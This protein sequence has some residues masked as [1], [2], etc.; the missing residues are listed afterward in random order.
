M[1]IRASFYA[2]NKCSQLHKHNIVNFCVLTLGKRK[3]QRRGTRFDT[4][5]FLFF[6]VEKGVIKWCL[7]MCLVNKLNALFSDLV[8]LKYTNFYQHFLLKMTLKNFCGIICIFLIKLNFKLHK[9][10]VM[11]IKVFKVVSEASFFWF[12]KKN[13]MIFLLIVI[14]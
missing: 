1:I 8:Y 7:Q 3:Y 9:S 14:Q 10:T 11:K 6:C 13:E 12:M 4:S 2:W 5:F